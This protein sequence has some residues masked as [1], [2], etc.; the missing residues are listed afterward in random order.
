MRRTRRLH[1]AAAELRAVV[2]PVEPPVVLEG[3]GGHEP[4]VLARR[5][6]EL[7]E[8]QLAGRGRRLERV[9]PATQP[10]GVEGVDPGVDLV[11]LE[12]LLGRVL[13]LDD[14]LDRAELAADDAPERRGIRG[15]DAG[16]RDRGIVL[17]PRLDDGREVARR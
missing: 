8:I 15:E 4:A 7:G 3:D 6:D 11:G 14:P 17:A 5:S 2:D 16:Q 9:D 1:S 12:L 10:G 13:R